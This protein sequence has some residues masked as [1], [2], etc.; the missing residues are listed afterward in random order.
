MR[1]HIPKWFPRVYVPLVLWMT[2]TA[3]LLAACEFFG[4]K[5][6]LYFA[7]ASYFIGFFLAIGSSARINNT[8]G[9]KGW[10]SLLFD[11]TVFAFPLGIFVIAFLALSEK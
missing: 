1:F 9:I 3:L 8:R 2:I 4:S 5:L 7:G 11:Y 6:I 10:L